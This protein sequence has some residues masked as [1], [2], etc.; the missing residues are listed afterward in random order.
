MYVKGCHVDEI[1]EQDFASSGGR[2]RKASFFNRKDSKSCQKIKGVTC[3]GNDLP[4]ASAKGGMAI[5]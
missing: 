5:G 4:I 1:V 3:G 2:L